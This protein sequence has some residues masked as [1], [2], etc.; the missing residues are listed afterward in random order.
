M[1][2]HPVVERVTARIIEKSKAGRTRYLELMANEAGK[3]GN[4]G[5]LSCSN[6]AHGFAAALE[7]SGGAPG[8]PGPA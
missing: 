8:L 5:F 7:D 2:L 3:H 4:R 1:T 6:L